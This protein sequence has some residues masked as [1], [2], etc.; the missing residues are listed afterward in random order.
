MSYFIFVLLRALFE[1]L[2][3]AF[4]SAIPPSCLPTPEFYLVG[5]LPNPLIMVLPKDSNEQDITYFDVTFVVSIFDF[6]Y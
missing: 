4:V 1:K 6:C 2:S 5:L 3:L